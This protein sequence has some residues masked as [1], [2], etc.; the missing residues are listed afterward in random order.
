MATA[1]QILGVP[2]SGNPRPVTYTKP[3]TGRDVPSHTPVQIYYKAADGKIKSYQSPGVKPL[4]FVR[5]A[6]YDEKINSPVPTVI[7]VISV[8]PPIQETM[9]QKTTATN[10]ATDQVTGVKKPKKMVDAFFDAI[11]RWLPAR[12]SSVAVAAT[13]KP[14]P[15]AQPDKAF[16][17]EMNRRAV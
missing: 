16:T 12:A 10:T 7:P 9:G 6:T 11:N 2:G 8:R 17:A 4:D 5:I 15:A 13:A 1:R 14:G 3:Y